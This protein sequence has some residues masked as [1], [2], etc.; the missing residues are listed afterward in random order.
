MRKWRIR[1]LQSDRVTQRVRVTRTRV[2]FAPRRDRRA[3]VAP[4]RKI[5]YVLA[6]VLLVERLTDWLPTPRTER[7]FVLDQRQ[8]CESVEVVPLIEL[9]RSDPEVSGGPES[10]E[11]SSMLRAAKMAGEKS[12]TTAKLS[13]S[14]FAE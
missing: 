6:F 10:S 5:R 7:T 12:G 3:R 1:S 14:S 4:R 9:G 2:L 13:T 11:D 8:G